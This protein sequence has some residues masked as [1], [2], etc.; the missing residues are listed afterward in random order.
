MGSG[1][2]LLQNAALQLLNMFKKQDH[3]TPIMYLFTGF[4]SFQD[5][6]KKHLVTVY[7]SQHGL[8]PLYIS[9]ILT[10]IAPPHPQILTPWH[11]GSVLFEKKKGQ[12]Q[13]GF[14]SGSTGIATRDH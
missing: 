7:K 9:G 11:I 12:G 6:L 1:L 10:P 8:A 5:Q 4:G 3:I 2:N 14:C 13:G